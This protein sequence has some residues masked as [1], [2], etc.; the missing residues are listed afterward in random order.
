MSLFS[1]PFNVNIKCMNLLHLVYSLSQSI[2]SQ[3]TNSEALFSTFSFHDSYN[4]S[5]SVCFLLPEKFKSFM[6]LSSRNIRV[7]R[8]G[9]VSYSSPAN[10]LF[11]EVHRTRSRIYLSVVSLGSSHIVFIIS[12]LSCYFVFSAPWSFF[13]TPTHS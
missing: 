5:L 12:T 4:L 7:Y 8:A 2:L 10:R 1:E 3:S 9:C 11:L 13:L 6:Y